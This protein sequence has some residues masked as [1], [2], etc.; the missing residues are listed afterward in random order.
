MIEYYISFVTDGWFL[1]SLLIWG[2]LRFFIAV[3]TYKKVGVNYYVGILLDITFI[4]FVLTIFY[5][6]ILLF[7]SVKN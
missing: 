1:V 7:L 3:F 5:F 2:F 6:N 4:C